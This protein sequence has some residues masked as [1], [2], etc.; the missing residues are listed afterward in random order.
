MQGATQ[1]AVVLS[2]LPRMSKPERRRGALEQL[3]YEGLAEDYGFYLVRR[4][5]KT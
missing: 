4:L 2:Y 1:A 5:L 3:I